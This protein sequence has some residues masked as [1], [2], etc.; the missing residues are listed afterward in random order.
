MTKTSYDAELATAAEE[1][2]L[3]ETDWRAER[4]ATLRL[5]YLV[6]RSKW[7]RG[8]ASNSNDMIALMGSDHR[9]PVECRSRRPAPDRGQLHPH[10]SD[11]VSPL[12][13]AV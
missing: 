12:R 9:C 1:L 3:P 6:A 4:L 2:G 11:E 10:T 7:A 13:Q 8:E 5:M